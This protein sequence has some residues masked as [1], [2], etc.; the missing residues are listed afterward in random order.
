M[1]K[2]IEWVII[3]ILGLFITY[4]ISIVANEIIQEQITHSLTDNGEVN[5]LLSIIGFVFNVLSTG[6]FEFVVGIVIISL[7]LLKADDE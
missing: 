2:K 3:E 5:L 6:Y 1:I 4:Q 7:T